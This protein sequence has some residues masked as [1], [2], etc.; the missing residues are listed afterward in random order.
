LFPDLVAPGVNV[1]T[2]DVS[3]AGVP[4]YQSFSGTSYAAP[5]LAGAAAL[6]YAAAPGL[7]VGALEE[8]LRASAKD[9]GPPG[10][11]DAS[12]YGLVDVCAAYAAVKGLQGCNGH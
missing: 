8:A 4:Q 6:L 9:V 11:D 1:Q 12:G 3:L 5:H 10:P 2:A 7:T